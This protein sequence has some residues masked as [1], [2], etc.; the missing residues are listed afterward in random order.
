MAACSAGLENAGRREAEKDARFGAK[1]ISS[2]HIVNATA[3]GLRCPESSCPAED[4]EGACF[5]LSATLA[6]PGFATLLI[7]PWDAAQLGRTDY[8][9]SSM[10]RFRG[11]SILRARGRAPKPSSARPVGNTRFCPQ[12]SPQHVHDGRVR[13]SRASCGG[14]AAGTPGCHL[15][16]EQSA[17]G[18]FLSGSLAL[19]SIP[20][21]VLSI[22]PPTLRNNARQSLLL[23]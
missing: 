14:A 12:P 17:L 2:H 6:E 1:D 23:Q 4:A 22:R 10:G 8:A 5:K 16:D 18:V 7:R 19:R 3:V 9:D 21:E 15:E 20:A 11:C 13:E